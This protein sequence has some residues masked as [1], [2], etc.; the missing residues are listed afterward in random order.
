VDYDGVFVRWTFFSS[1]SR[2]C[3]NVG[4]A[5][6]E[7][8]SVRGWPGRMPVL[9]EGC[10]AEQCLHCGLQRHMYGFGINLAD[11][12]QISKVGFNWFAR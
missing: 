8:W 2:S 3:Y 12:G 10:E 11:L 4:M 9:S 7:L 6:I 1:R 5:A